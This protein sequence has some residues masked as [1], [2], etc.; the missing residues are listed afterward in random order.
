[1]LFGLETSVMDEVRYIGVL[2]SGNTISV[3]SSM[4][5]I[6]N[7][8]GEVLWSAQTQGLTEITR[9]NLT[10]DIKAGDR[11]VRIAAVDAEQATEILNTVLHYRPWIEIKPG[12]FVVT[13]KSG[14]TLRITT[15]LLSVTNP[16][17]ETL[18]SYN[19]S[20]ILSIK[21]FGND[22]ELDDGSKKIRLQ[23]AN[24]RQATVIED[25]IRDRSPNIEPPPSG[26]FAWIGKHPLFAALIVGGVIVGGLVIVGQFSEDDSGRRVSSSSR[27]TATRIRSAATSTPSGYQVEYIVTHSLNG[28][29]SLTYENDSGG[30]E[31]IDTVATSGEWS[32]SYRMDIGDFVYLSVQNGEDRGTVTCEIRIN[33][34]SWKKSTSSGSYVIA[35]CSGSVGFE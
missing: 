26:L 14:N 22:L 11:D 29:I 12:T 33:N 5:E 13:L 9:S 30:T 10:L 6:S 17:G 34:R 15:S 28:E 1:M 31:Q 27:P 8:N 3:N 2:K 4:C 35:S 19:L 23:A 32:R 16:V 25:K 7:S 18:I 20:K 24:Q 21:R